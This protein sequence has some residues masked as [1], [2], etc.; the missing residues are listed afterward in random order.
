MNK[1][2]SYCSIFLL[3]IFTAVAASAA[4]WPTWRG[5]DGTGVSA[6]KNLP[7]TWSTT[8]NVRWRIALPGPGNSSPIV[9]GNRVFV[10]QALASENRRTLMCLD[11]A[12][13][14]LLWQSGVTYTEQEQTQ[15]SNPYCSA[16]PVTDGKQ[17]IASFGSAGLFCYDFT[18]Q[19]LWHRDFG[20]MNHIFGNAASPILYGDL[21][22]LNFGPDEKARLIAV[23][24]RDGQTLWEVAPPKVDPSEQSPMGGP[25]G[26]GGFGPG[27]MLAPLMFAQA[28]KQDDQKLTKAEFLALADTWFDKLDP[29]KTGKLSREQFVQKLGDVL[30][31][32][33][34][35]GPPGETPPETGQRSGAGRRFGPAGMVGPGLFTAADADKDGALTRAELK[36]SFENWF[37]AWDADKSG[38][39]TEEQL[40]AGLNAV[41]PQPQFG[42]PGGPSGPGGPGRGRGPGG[43]SGGSWSTPLVVQADGRAELIL[44]FPNRLAAYDPQTGKQL[45]LSKGLGSSIYTSPVCGE[46]VA[47]ARSSGMSGTSA[48]AVKLG[49]QGDVTESRRIWRMDR[50]KSAVGSG[51]IYD[52]HIYSIDQNGIAECAEL[53]TGNKVWEERLKGSGSRSGAWSSLLLADG[54]IFVPNQSGDVFVLR[55]SPKFEL[56]ATNSVGESTNASLAV[57]NGEVFFRT[58]KS[59]WCFANGKL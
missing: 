9:W 20:K 22:I 59:L 55:A 51:V 54:K 49:G 40:R 43:P 3:T 41:L 45:W 24:K 47:V 42:G 17:V 30:P 58:D 52:G 33:H 37:S 10:T 48:V 44:C 39:I 15:Q 14:K 32:P 38:R 4:D 7:Q 27:M 34:G 50:V 46:G 1:S 19:E 57:S 29:D 21:C 53:K 6:E 25:G 28:G 5:P 31:P 2:L 16:S 8:E 26:R 11:R 12:D 35:F 18:G 13:G 23:N 36:A 56:L